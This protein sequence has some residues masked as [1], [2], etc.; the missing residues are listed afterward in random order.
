MNG[1]VIGPAGAGLNPSATANALVLPGGTSDIAPY[2]DLPNGMISALT[3]ATF[4]GWYTVN[5][6]QNWGRMFDFGST[7]DGRT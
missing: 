5:S 4:E 1:T 3:N 6:I 2:V 7:T